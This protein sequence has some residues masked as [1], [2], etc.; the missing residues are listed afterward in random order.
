MCES[1]N[2]LF[3]N[4]FPPLMF[5]SSGHL[6]ISLGYGQ[7]GVGGEEWL[8][9]SQFDNRMLSSHAPRYPKILDWK[10]K[11][12]RSSSKGNNMLDLNSLR[13]KSTWNQNYSIIKDKLI[14]T[15]TKHSVLRSLKSFLP[16]NQIFY[17]EPVILK[18]IKWNPLMRN[19]MKLTASH[20]LYKW[21]LQTYQHPAQASHSTKESNTNNFI[22]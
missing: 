7:G 21:S 22:F 16:D 13:R 11:A 19:K 20:L 12:T 17:N 8:L 1:F 5:C 3:T 10:V 15:H 18:Q 6:K 4:I 9:I 2:E 14:T